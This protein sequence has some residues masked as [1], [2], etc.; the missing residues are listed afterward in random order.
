V[1][2]KAPREG[3]IHLV[4]AE[5]PP[6]AEARHAHELPERAAPTGKLVPVP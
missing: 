2:I 6:L 3:R 4:V 5:R 1:L